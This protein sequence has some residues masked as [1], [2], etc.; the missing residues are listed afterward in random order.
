M[1]KS[2]DGSWYPDPIKFEI[3][4]DH[5]LDTKN[6]SKDL[7]KK[8]FISVWQSSMLSECSCTYYL[9]GKFDSF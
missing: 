3:N 6:N 4:P 9:W 8:L 7:K 2:E 1:K 5:C